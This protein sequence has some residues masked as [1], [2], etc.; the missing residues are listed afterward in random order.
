MKHFIQS[1]NVLFVSFLLLY[2]SGI[3]CGLWTTYGMDHLLRDTY[4]DAFR[5]GFV[6]SG[7]LVQDIMYSALNAFIFI[8][9]MFV[10]G[11][12]LIGLPV[13]HGLCFFKAFQHGMV[14]ALFLI[15]S[16]T[17]G[18]FQILFVLFPYATFEILS[19]LCVFVASMTLSKKLWMCLFDKHS[20]ESYMSVFNHQLNRFVFR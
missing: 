14:I 12:S 1:S 15:E 16:Y 3:I 10:M 20:S 13:I 8:G 19:M 11:V 7:Y 17:K 6:S 5:S 18:I 4:L 2:G 9:V